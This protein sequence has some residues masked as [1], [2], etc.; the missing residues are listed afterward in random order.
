MS[1]STIIVFFLIA[2]AGI[3]L[4]S[5]LFSKAQLV[6]KQSE[7]YLLNSLKDSSLSAENRQ[8]LEDKLSRILQ[9]KQTMGSWKLVLTIGLVLMV[10]SYALYNHMGNPEAIHYIPQQ[11]NNDQANTQ[12]TGQ[13]LPQISMQEAIAQ[14]E[15]RL[16]KNPDDV[17]GQMLY[18][19]SQIS[20]KN[21]A[22]AVTAYRK[23]N[24]LA[25]NESVI[26]TELAEAIALA[27]NNHSFLGEPEQLLT[28]AVK[29]EADNQKALWLLGMVNYEKNN[30]QK[31]NELWSKLYDLMSDQAAKQQLSEQL[32]DIRNK[33]G[34]DSSLSTADASI[35]NDTSSQTAS[36]DQLTINISITSELLQNLENKKALLYV[37]S[38]ASSG[39][40]MPIAVVRKPIPQ[41]NRGFPITI[42]MNDSNS[43]QANRKLSDFDSIKLGARISFSGNAM[44][45]AGDLQ[46]QELI[47]DLP[48][49]KA[50]ELLIDTIKQ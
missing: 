1:T 39:M 9:Q 36:K 34:I 45:Q 27:N 13:A 6:K 23:A 33:L 41:D 17:D 42:Q 5:L 26:M 25:A 15:A 43:L 14:L 29:L 4:F 32:L 47:L 44:P 46:S 37:Y 22:K 10:S 19:R 11:I 18:A 12:Q 7:K 24:A 20:L 8:A 16:L 2:I 30:L 31:T 40:P 35:A 50:I 48:S 28:Q 3:G 38:K 21:Y 49:D